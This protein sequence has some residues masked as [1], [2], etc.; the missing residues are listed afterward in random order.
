MTRESDLTNQGWDKKG[1]YD[2]PRLAEIIAT[3]KD[4]GLEVHLEPYDPATDPGCNECMKLN[5]K[6]YKTIYTRVKV[7]SI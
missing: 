3:Y 2:E 6:K 4:I 7:S 5:P 1:T